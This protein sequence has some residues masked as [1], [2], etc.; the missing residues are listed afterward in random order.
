MDTVAELD[1]D[2]DRDP[3]QQ[4]ATV[5]EDEGHH[6]DLAV[7][8]ETGLPEED[9]ATNVKEADLEK[10]DPG[11]QLHEAPSTT[12]PDVRSRGVRRVKKINV[13]GTP[14]PWM[15]VLGDQ[16]EVRT[17]VQK[18]QK[19][20]GLEAQTTEDLGVHI[21]DARGVLTVG[22]LVVRLTGGRTDQPLP[23]R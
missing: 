1:H 7:D 23:V 14:A 17:I 9:T 18:V 5:H 20:D 13:H 8:L 15:L 12:D 16:L 4:T 2:L 6:Q 10:I 11:A 3:D 22:E 19:I 21:I